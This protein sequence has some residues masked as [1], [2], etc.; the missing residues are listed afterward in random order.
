MNPIR[1]RVVRSSRI[2][3]R[4][5]SLDD[6]K[7]ALGIGALALGLVLVPAATPTANPSFAFGRVGG[8]ILP[9]TVRISSQGTLSTTGPVHLRNPERKLTSAALSRL[10]GRAQKERFFA[11]PARIGCPGALPDFASMYVTVTTTARTKRAL[12]HGE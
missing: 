9:Y 11:L 7:I 10:L 6:V 3:H 1:L 2:R 8:N 4:G 12:A 5:V